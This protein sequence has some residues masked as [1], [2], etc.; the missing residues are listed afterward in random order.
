MSSDGNNKT[1][2]PGSTKTPYWQDTTD[3]FVGFFDLLGF[4]N[5]VFRNEHATV[6]KRMESLNQILTEIRQNEEVT[7]SKPGFTGSPKDH[8]DIDNV[9]VRPIIFSDSI[10]LVSSD[11]SAASANK[12]LAVSGWLISRCMIRGIAMKGALAFGQQTADFDRSL[13]FGQPLIDAYELQDEFLAYGAILHCS[14]EQFARKCDLN[15]YFKFL[16]PFDVPLK[17]GIVKHQLVDWTHPLTK[18]EC[19]LQHVESF[20]DSVS[21]TARKYVDNTAS[22]TRHL[23]SRQQT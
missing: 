8:Q 14:M 13:Y 5:F 2:A 17:G 3:R 4:K 7:L 22:Y 19:A 9:A 11:S 6:K 15:Q 16:E 18:R 12:L 10:L 21:G 1:D 23:M 20:Y